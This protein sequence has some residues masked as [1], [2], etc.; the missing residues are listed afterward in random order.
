MTRKRDSKGRFIKKS[1]LDDVE[2][3]RRRV[4]TGFYR[5]HDIRLSYSENGQF[6]PAH[7]WLKE[8]DLE[9]LNQT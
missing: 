6:I 4:L 7:S 1:V 8:S 9:W 3:E 5:Q 2:Q